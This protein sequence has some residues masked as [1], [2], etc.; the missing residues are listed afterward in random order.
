M[1]QWSVGGLFFL[2][3]TTRLRVVGLGYGQMMRITYA[4][5]AAAAF[6]IGLAWNASPLQN[7][8]ACVTAIASVGAL[9]QSVR[10]RSAGVSGQTAIATQRSER[11][12]AM[13]GIDRA[14]QQKDATATEFDPN[15]D[16]IAP[17]AGLLGVVAVGVEAGGPVW[18]HLARLIVGALF[19]G[20]VSDAMLLG[21]WYLVQPGLGR[22]PLRDLV[23]WS[24]VLLLPEVALLLI[25][26]GMFSVFSGAIND[27]YG[28]ILGWFWIASALTT[29]G[30]FFM[31]WVA[32]KEKQYSAV[33]A[34][35]GL[36][37]LAILTA[38]SIDLVARA[39]L[40]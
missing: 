1:L 32:L 8:A 28:G 21:H 34:A 38:F 23:L 18:L 36:L 7:A 22:K 26:T 10:Y 33:M 30:L 25:P 29:A 35:T 15:Y 27:G 16:L 5:M 4:L 24:S 6:S 11:V 37:Y 14:P 13:T 3:V 39:L 20:V 40:R 19:L 12:A 2:W 17:A 9:T 31:S